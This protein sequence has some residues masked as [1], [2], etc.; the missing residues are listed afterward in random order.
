VP[1][2]INGDMIGIPNR[3]RRGTAAAS[4]LRAF[5]AYQK[6]CFYRRHRSIGARTRRCAAL[7]PQRYR[8]QHAPRVRCRAHRGSVRH[9]ATLRRRRNGSGQSSPAA[10]GIVRRAS[11]K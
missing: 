5:C 4:S 11:K 7:P 9:R 2:R 1:S 10:P 8:R 6:V 3:R